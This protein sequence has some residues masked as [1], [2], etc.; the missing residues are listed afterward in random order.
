M[1]S[2]RR[3][4]PLKRV[5]L[6]LGIIAIVGFDVLVLTNPLIPSR[7]FIPL[8]YPAMLTGILVLSQLMVRVRN[9]RRL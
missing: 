1:T 7:L 5:L 9:K 2:S 8:W 3:T 6:L 4:F